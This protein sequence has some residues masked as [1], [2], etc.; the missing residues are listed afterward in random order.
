MNGQYL[1]IDFNDA[2]LQKVAVVLKY[3]KLIEQWA[4]YTFAFLKQK[5]YKYQ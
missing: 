2:K 5:Y 3:Y 4:G 1:Q